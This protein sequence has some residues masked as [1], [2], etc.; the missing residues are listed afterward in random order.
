MQLITDIPAA[1]EWLTTVDARVKWMEATGFQIQWNQLTPTR[2]EVIKRHCFA[3]QV[4]EQITQATDQKKDAS[5]VRRS[6]R[7]TATAVALECY[8]ALRFHPKVYTE[9][10]I[11][12]LPP[13]AMELVKL[14]VL[15]GS[16][17]L[18]TIDGTLA[19]VRD[20]ANEAIIECCDIITEK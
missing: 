11:T 1:P 16:I 2:L 5:E 15:A 19:E 14:H 20:K 12:Y 10:R 8:N 3:S 4:L 17:V 6:I 18:D 9:T 13:V 7:K